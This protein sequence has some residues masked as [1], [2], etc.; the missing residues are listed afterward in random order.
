MI[1][2]DCLDILTEQLF[3]HFFSTPSAAG[4]PKILHLYLKDAKLFVVTSLGFP[5]LFISDSSLLNCH[6]LPDVSE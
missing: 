5:A 2:K 6:K 4:V 1:A 3:L